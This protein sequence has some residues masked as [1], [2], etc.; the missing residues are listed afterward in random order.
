MG[1]KVAVREPKKK[2]NDADS[3]RKELKRRNSSRMTIDIDETS[4]K[5]VSVQLREALRQNSSV[6]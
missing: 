2:K 5:P 1:E 4:D 6:R 3:R